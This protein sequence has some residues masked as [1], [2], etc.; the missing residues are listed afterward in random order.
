M[1]FYLLAY[2]L[3]ERDPDG[4][5]IRFAVSDGPTPMSWTPLADGA[6]I[7]IS[8]VGERGVRDPFLVRDERRNRFVVIATDLRT[9]PEHDWNRAVRYGSRSIVVWE[10]ADLVNWDGP[11]LVEVAP[12]DAGNTWAPKAFW[13]NERGC[14]LL[15]WASALHAGSPRDSNGYQRIL[16]APTQDFRTFGPPE[17]YLDFGHDVIDAT[18][19][20]DGAR[21][22]RFSANAMSQPRGENRGN[23]IYMERGSSLEDPDYSPVREDLGREVLVRGEGPATAPATAHPGWYLLIDECGLRGY[24]LFETNNL[25]SGDWIWLEQARLPERARHGSLMPITAEERERLLSRYATR[26][27]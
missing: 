2:F 10:S 19:I 12:P 21:W 25:E 17:I 7:L 22:Y 3:D 24:Q 14:W 5:Q 27:L 8:T 20:D 23:H 1:S 18:F 11:T 16:M 26:G 9:W 15:F 4:E 13:S 6:P